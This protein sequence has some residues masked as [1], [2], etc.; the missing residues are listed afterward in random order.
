MYAEGGAAKRRTSPLVLLF[1]FA[2][3]G[4]VC[5]RVAPGFLRHWALSRHRAVNLMQAPPFRSPKRTPPLSNHVL[6]HSGDLQAAPVSA[7]LVFCMSS[8]C[9]RGRRAARKSL[10]GP[11]PIDCRRN[12]RPWRKDV[13][14]CCLQNSLSTGVR[15]EH[16]KPGNSTRRIDMFPW[17]VSWCKA[18]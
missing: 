2:V 5:L 7:P 15:A 11:P 8:G 14:F 18:T 16:T 10:P 13:N 17:R 4:E 3:V 1:F 12:G 9:S 6:R